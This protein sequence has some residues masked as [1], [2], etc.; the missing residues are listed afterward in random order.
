MI[1]ETTQRV[2]TIGVLPRCRRRANGGRQA[3][4]GDRPTGSPNNP[5]AT[6]VA[7]VELAVNYLENRL[8]IDC[9]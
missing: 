9:G 8:N 4:G 5:L 7:H 1:E 3:R 6:L 2:E